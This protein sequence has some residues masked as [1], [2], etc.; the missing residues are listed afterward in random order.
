VGV[1]LLAPVFAELIQ[2]YLGDL[3]GVFGLLFFVVFLA[4]LY[5]GAV[6]LI[7]EVTVRTGRGWPSRLLLATAFGVAMPTLVDVSLWSPRTTPTS[8]TGT[9]S[10]A[11]PSSM[12]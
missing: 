6:L 4:P 11:P 8:T 3:G 7:R 12:A 1:V 10:W 5:G 2:A 9:T